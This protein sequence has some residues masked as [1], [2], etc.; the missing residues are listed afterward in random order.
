MANKYQEIMEKLG[1]NY[2]SAD[3][4]LLSDLVSD[5][6]LDEMEKRIG[7]RL[8]NDYREFLR[9]YSGYNCF[10]AY[11][12]F[13]DGCNQT[14]YLC[15]FESGRG[16]AEAYHSIIETIGLDPFPEDYYPGLILVRPPLNQEE[17]GWPAEL[18]PI[19]IDGALNQ[20]CLALFGL[21]T[22]A[23]FY[24]RSNPHPDSQNLYLIADSFDE[25][26]HLLRKDE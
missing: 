7:Y 11:P 14:E 3:P 9:D 13:G 8:P 17:I 6:I 20:I 23:V 4:I 18:L 1:A 12:L 25:F 21:R 15:N 26:M 5:E 19:A 2:S 22:G 10:A 24:W 16:L